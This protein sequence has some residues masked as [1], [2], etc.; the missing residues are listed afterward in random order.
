MQ[1][2]VGIASVGLQFALCAV[3]CGAWASA[4]AV[5][6]S[7]ADPANQ[8]HRYS[9]A[10]LEAV[11]DQMR[12]DT[13][14]SGLTDSAWISV[15]GAGRTYFHKS[16]CYLELVRRTGRADLCPKVIERRTLLGNGAAH[17]P[18]ACTELAQQINAH[19]AQG[20][21][22]TQAHRQA[23]LAVMQDVFKLGAVVAT[24][25]PSG[26]WQLRADVDG[27]TAG[28]YRVEIDLVREGRRLVTQS[29]A[30]SQPQTLQWTLERPSVVALSP[31][32]NIFAVVVRLIYL[33]PGAGGAPGSEAYSTSRNLTL[34]AQ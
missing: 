16:A 4:R 19:R 23:Y 11:C 25:L 10:E 34:S 32:P 22:D 33:P 31:V 1:P 15:P 7:S 24:D 20:D 8:Y 30:L 13:Y 12:P 18:R 3:V 9:N 28:N 6:G 21:R 17:S 14:A 5:D 26:A 29:L 2:A 27:K